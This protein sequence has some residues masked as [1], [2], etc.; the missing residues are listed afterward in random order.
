[1]SLNSPTESPPKS[2]HHHHHPD[3]KGFFKRHFSL[4]KKNED[5]GTGEQQVSSSTREIN[6]DM[7]NLSLKSENTHTTQHNQHS[8]HNHN[9]NKE[10]PLAIQTHSDPTVQHTDHVL[11]PRTE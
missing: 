9:H 3:Y 2:P 8:S 6:E 1:M 10:A 5:S 4:N 7:A 11:T